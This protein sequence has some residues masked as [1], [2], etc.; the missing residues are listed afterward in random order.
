[1]KQA[2]TKEESRIKLMSEK[3]RKVFLEDVPLT[4]TKGRYPIITL[5]EGV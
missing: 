3:V 2:L 4:M 5:R 1:M